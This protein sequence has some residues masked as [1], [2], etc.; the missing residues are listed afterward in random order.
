MAVAEI[1]SDP[2]VLLEGVDLD[3]R[4]AAIAV[5]VEAGYERAEAQALAARASGMAKLKK[6]PGE[7]EET[8][9]ATAERIATSVELFMSD[10]GK[11]HATFEVDGH[12]ETAAV[13]SRRF[14]AWV[15]LRFRDEKGKAPS[16]DALSVAQTQAE[17]VAEFSGS[18]V[19]VCTRVGTANGK[20][21]VDLGDPAWR[22]I[23]IDA[24]GWRIVDNPPVKFRRPSDALALP[25]PVSGGSLGLLR[26]FV[27]APADEAWAMMRAWLIGALAPKGP[28]PILALYGEQGS[29]KSTTSRRL[30]QVFDP[31]RTVSRETP[32][33]TQDLLIAAKACRVLAYDNLSYLS[34]DMSDA[35]CR[36]A[37]GAGFGTRT[38]Y[39]DDEESTF[40][41]S[42]PVIVNGIEEVATRGDLLSR[43]VVLNLPTL[44]SVRDEASMDAEWE[45]AHPMILGAL[46][47]AVSS[48]L[49]HWDTTKLDRAPRMADFA[50]W[51]IASGEVPDFLEIYDTNR[52]DA[53]GTELDA[54]PFASAVLSFAEQMGEWEG[55]AG[56]LLALL[57]HDGDAKGWPTNAKGC[58]DRLRRHAPAFRTRGVEVTFRK[59]G[60]RRL[61]AISTDS[62]PSEPVGLGL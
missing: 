40:Y 44:P 27:N 4:P 49:R 23:E 45:Q 26:P 1:K 21:Y 15:A 58:G 14:K 42:R 43:A 20:V 48:A 2:S 9:R 5:L 33:K 50:R 30:R 24:A 22:A 16:S 54:S 12:R 41:A 19:E 37:T 6:S 34:A 61:V 35:L 38:L 57:D 51:V 46:L 3:D 31:S 13:R 11:A 62:E 56:E 25:V 36:L 8:D 47:D 17:A 28:F 32:K 29:A 59:S 18:V 7:A 60:S 39:T 52:S 53:I 55:T 10:D